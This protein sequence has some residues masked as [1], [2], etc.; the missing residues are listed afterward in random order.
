M[1]LTHRS[2]SEGNALLH[3]NCNL[4]NMQFKHNKEFKQK[5]NLMAAFVQISN[6]KRFYSTHSVTIQS[7]IK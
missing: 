5:K 1:A 2:Q 7:L 6:D 4:N 3:N